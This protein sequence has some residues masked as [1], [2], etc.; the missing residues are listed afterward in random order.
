MKIL[1]IEDEISLAR[2]VKE[3]LQSRGF[4]V[5]HFAD[6]IEWEAHIGGFFSGRFFF[7]VLVRGQKGFVIE[8]GDR[9]R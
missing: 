1:Y 9:E 6:G 3:S 5:I 4:E 8:G 2:I 7:E